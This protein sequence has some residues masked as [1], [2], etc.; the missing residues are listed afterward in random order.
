M[1]YLSCTKNDFL[2]F[3]D[4]ENPSVEPA[5]EFSLSRAT[6]CVLIYQQDPQSALDLPQAIFVRPEE[7]RE[8]F[9]F[10][11]TYSQRYLPFSSFFKVVTN[12]LEVASDSIAPQK[13]SPLNGAAVSISIAEAFV[14]SSL[15]KQNRTI[16]DLS[17]Q[18]CLSTFSY[19]VAGAVYNNYDTS[20]LGDLYERWASVRSFITNDDLRITPHRLASAW[21]AILSAQ[22]TRGAGGVQIPEMQHV[23]AGLIRD[24]AV[25]QYEWDG[26]LR[27]MPEVKRLSWDTKSPRED[28]IAN[29]QMVYRE[30]VY[31]TH[32]PIELREFVAGAFT[33]MLGE[34][35]FLYLPL[36]ATLSDVLPLAAFWYAFMCALHPKTDA[37]SVANSLAL[38][39]HKHLQDE[40]LSRTPCFDISYD[41]AIM[42]AKGTVRLPPFRTEIQSIIAVEILPRIVARFGRAQR[43]QSNAP[44]QLSR[45]VASYITGAEQLLDRLRQAATSPANGFDPKSAPT[46]EPAQMGLIKDNEP[47]K[48]RRPAKR[49]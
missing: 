5:S 27:G 46:Q 6:Y 48:K 43:Q 28:R 49:R 47:L 40:R 37:L 7:M 24:G 34:G 16:D 20:I 25:P 22:E 31:N 14:Q 17:L 13:S 3:L 33:S 9:A 35:S 29:L 36:V 12:P 42:L 30:L 23:I 21:Q 45:A 8:F 1:R 4:G 2:R 39:V 10:V 26:L 18:A 38:R 41:E 44:S 11:T 15:D 19:A 32:I